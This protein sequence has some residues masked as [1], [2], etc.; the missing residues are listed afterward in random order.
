MFQIN[1]VFNER[2]L[3]LGEGGIDRCD[4]LLDGNGRIDD[5]IQANIMGF[6]KMAEETAPVHVPLA[7]SLGLVTRRWSC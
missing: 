6:S 7:G 5:M 4:A 2:H 1:T 3:K